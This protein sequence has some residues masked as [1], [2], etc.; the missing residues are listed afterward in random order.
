MKVSRKVGR[1][2]HS[3]VSRRRLR[4]KKTKSGYRK[5]HTQQGGRRSRGHKR[6]RTYKRGKRFHRGGEKGCESLE[7]S[8]WTTTMSGF[9]DNKHTADGTQN[10]F[11]TYKKKGSL[12]SDSSDFSIE[13]K[14]RS[15]KA[16]SRYISDIVLKRQTSPHITCMITDNQFDSIIESIRKQKNEIVVPAYINDNLLVTAVYGLYDFSFQSNLQCFEK[17]KTLLEQ[18]ISSLPQIYEEEHNNPNPAMAS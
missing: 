15:S 7:F 10:I 4:N 8:D 14:T 12:M 3:S 2:N 9:G 6:A 13:F 18:K 17:V 11:L 16:V 1:R 5:K